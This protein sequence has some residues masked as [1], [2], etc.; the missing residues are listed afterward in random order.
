MLA[1]VDGAVYFLQLVR[2][3]PDWSHAWDRVDTEGAQIGGGKDKIKHIRD[4]RGDLIVVEVEVNS[5]FDNDI[6]EFSQAI[7][8]LPV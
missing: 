8:G 5:I 3:L 6:D 1:S 4:R 2:V 7:R